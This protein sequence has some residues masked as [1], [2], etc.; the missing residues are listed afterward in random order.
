MRGDDLGQS[1]HRAMQAMGGRLA[2]RLQQPRE[3][4]ITRRP[5]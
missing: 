5:A 4:T 3:V 1:L 2:G